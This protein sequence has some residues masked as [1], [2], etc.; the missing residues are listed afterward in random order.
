M[1]STPPD[2][3]LVVPVFDEEESLPRLVEEI[4][5]ALAPLAL[6]WELLLVDDGSRDGSGRFAC[7]DA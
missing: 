1:P 3:S 4:R 2:L 7:G 5:T 6:T